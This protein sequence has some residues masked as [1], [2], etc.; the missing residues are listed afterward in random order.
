MV[1]LDSLV[2]S[3]RKGWLRLE[4]SYGFIS[5]LLECRQKWLFRICLELPIQFPGLYTYERSFLPWSSSRS[6]SC[7]KSY[8][9]CFR[10]FLGRNGR[11]KICWRNFVVAG[12]NAISSCSPWQSFTV[13]ASNKSETIS[14]T[15]YCNF[16]SVIQTVATSLLEDKG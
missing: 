11:N 14:T 3:H 12:L 6:H 5:V 1:P 7:S 2:M 10:P 13:S 9:M 8:P 15:M 16:M 4:I